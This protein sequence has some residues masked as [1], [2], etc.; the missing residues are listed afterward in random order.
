M[1][2]LDYD[3]DVREPADEARGKVF[4]EGW[5]RGAKWHKGNPDPYTP[6]VLDMLKWENLGYRMGTILGPASER[7]MDAM[8]AMCALLQDEQKREGSASV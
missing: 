4:R 1:E 7:F 3:K 2:R 6:G 8:F 5:R